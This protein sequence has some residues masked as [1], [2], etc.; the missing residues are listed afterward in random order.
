MAKTID[1][2]IKTVLN[3]A[4]ERTEKGADKQMFIDF[5]EL[6]SR[7]EELDKNNKG[8]LR[9][10]LAFVEATM[11]SEKAKKRSEELLA[12]RQRQEKNAEGKA[13]KHKAFVL[14]GG[15]L[16]L[17]EVQR[18]KLILEA[19]CKGAL[20]DGDMRKFGVSKEVFLSKKDV[21]NKMKQEKDTSIIL[22]ERYVMRGSEHFHVYDKEAR[23][24]TLVHFEF[25][26]Y[27]VYKLT[28]IIDDFVSEYRI[29]Q[30][31]EG[32]L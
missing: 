1:E 14:G 4:Q 32:R 21:E 27:E 10:L 16:G 29:D 18:N 28:K 11:R 7:R 6:A 3:F 24:S 19:C 20:S 31:V 23:R 30:M 22:M 12:K 5:V 9:Q 25:G 26:I 8:R 15:I 17:D 2:R 13:K